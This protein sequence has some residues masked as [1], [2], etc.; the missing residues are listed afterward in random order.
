MLS[1]YRSMFT[2]E[3]ADFPPVPV[4]RQIF[5]PREFF[6]VRRQFFRRRQNIP[7]ERDGGIG[8]RPGDNRHAVRN[9]EEKT[10]G[11]VPFGY[12]VV[13]IDGVKKLTENTGEQAA[14]KIMVAMRD[15]GESLR[16][17]ASRLRADGIAPKGGGE[18]S[19][20]VIRSII[21][22]AARNAA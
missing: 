4:L 5:F 17:I 14:I 12:D 15:A 13:A 11:I 16:T 3:R 22:R 8:N 21:L 6:R 19:A 18:W 2:M 9:T 1:S 20:K 10:G 7:P